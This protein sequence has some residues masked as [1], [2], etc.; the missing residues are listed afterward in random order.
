SPTPRGGGPRRGEGGVHASC[1]QSSSRPPPAISADQRVRTETS[2][3]AD[4]VHAARAPTPPP[5]RPLPPASASRRRSMPVRELET[6]GVTSKLK[7]RNHAGR[8]LGSVVEVG[9]HQDSAHRGPALLGSDVAHVAE[10]LR[11]SPLA[12][13]AGLQFDNDKPVLCVLRE[14]VYEAGID[15]A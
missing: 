12:G 10:D 5:S 11:N 8:R 7:V 13:H 15:G 1:R 2:C 6:H 4:N 14:D 9:S 3:A